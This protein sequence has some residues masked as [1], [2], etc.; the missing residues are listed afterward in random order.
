MMKVECIVDVVKRGVDQPELFELAH[1]LMP[2]MH[3]VG[4]EVVGE[5][6]NEEKWS[7]I[8]TPKRWIE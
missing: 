6:V 8:I 4:E 7:N 5:V 2:A 1:H 3:S